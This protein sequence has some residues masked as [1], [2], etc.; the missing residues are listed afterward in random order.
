[1][2][3]SAR[4][5]ERIDVTSQIFLGADARWQEEQKTENTKDSHCVLLPRWADYS[6]ARAGVSVKPAQAPYDYRLNGL[7]LIHVLTEK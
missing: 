3:I 2:A 1:M 6:P 4:T 7:T 5:D